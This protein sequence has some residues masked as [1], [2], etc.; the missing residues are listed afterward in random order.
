MISLLKS[1]FD[2]F[3]KRAVLLSSDKLTIY[4]WHR[5]ELGSSYLFEIDERGQANFER[6][7]QET[8]NIPIAIVVDIIEEEY[9]VDTIPHV[10]GPDRKAVLQRKQ[11]RLFRDS[12]YCNTEFQGRDEQGR[13]D[14]NVLFMSISNPGIIRPWLKL[15]G[16]YKVPLKGI[17]TLPL[18]SGSVFE[19]LANFS[20]NALIVSLQSISGL[21]QSYFQNKK[22]KISRLSSMPRYGTV[23][24]APKIID[25]VDKIRR[26]LAS[27]RLISTDEP[28]DIYFLAHGE[29][30]EDLNRQ[31]AD[32]GTVHYH[33]LDIDELGKNEGLIQSQISP[34]SDRF[35]MHYFLKRNMPNS[36]ASRNEMRYSRMRDLR[37]T[38]FALSFIIMLFSS[39]Y[40]G[41][42]F[43]SGANFKQQSDAA[44]KKTSFYSARYQMARERLPKTPVEP[45]DIEI[46]VKMAKT[47]DD[48][49]ATP[50]EMFKFLSSGLDAFSNI[51]LDNIDWLS[52][53]N[54]DENSE[55]SLN[56]SN[57]Q[58][59]VDYRYYQIA[60]IQAHLEPFDGDY[61][62][63]IATV[64]EFAEIL[65]KKGSVYDVNIISLPLDI[66]SNTS[67][68]GNTQAVGKEAMFKLRAVIGVGNETG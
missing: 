46:A 34:F 23:S 68:Q 59:E 6:Y 54:P 37:N 9:R 48:L 7:L 22:L 15:L 27:L 66:S 25:E 53:F 39:V 16:K 35:F 33:M 44:Q 62:K 41:L 29:L 45:V 18:I 51:K 26:Y 24:F 40:S 17:Y 56:N 5:G 14:D 61:R 64:N 28:L 58:K 65:R 30:L 47:L 36:Y 55:K 63:A 11:S 32:S 10:F 19:T 21:R 42:N 31:Q 20:N 60:T 1:K 38:M 12:P 43:M 57:S 50:L 8:P 13:K 49:K 67:L 2:F 4:H 52:G 3:N